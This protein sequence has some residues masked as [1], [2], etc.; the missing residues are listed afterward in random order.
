MSR[1]ED[2]QDVVAAQRARAEAQSELIEFEEAPG[3]SSVIGQSPTPGSNAVDSKYM[4]LLKQ[5]S[6][7]HAE[8]RL[9]LIFFS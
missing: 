5:V 1:L 4:E 7:R 8:T 2:E 6:L 9:I 3:G